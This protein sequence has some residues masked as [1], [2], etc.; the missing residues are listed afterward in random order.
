MRG[1]LFCQR[2]TLTSADHGPYHH[3]R[4]KE[5]VANIVEFFHSRGQPETYPRSLLDPCV[6]WSLVP[7]CDRCVW[8]GRVAR[9]TLVR[10]G[11]G[12]PHFPLVHGRDAMARR[13]EQRRCV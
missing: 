2:L 10:G 12:P 6:E 1:R 7:G 5:H 9:A 3:R 13:K 11:H 8:A 4:S